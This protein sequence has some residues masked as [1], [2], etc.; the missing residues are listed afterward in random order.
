M[1]STPPPDPQF[2]RTLDR[3]YGR[4]TLGFVGFVLVLGWL[5]Y[6]GWSRTAIG[7]TFL[8]ATLAVYATIGFL[9]RTI[10][11]VEYYV[12]GRRVP[13]FY[14]GMAIDRKSTRLNSSH[15]QKSRMPSSA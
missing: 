9:T 7:L 8:L 12:A 4:F 5:E 3:L 10:D 11:P 2:R 15:I 14:N 6:L 1:M 13:A